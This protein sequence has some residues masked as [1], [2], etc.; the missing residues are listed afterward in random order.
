MALSPDTFD[1]QSWQTAAILQYTWSTSDTRTN[2]EPSPGRRNS[3]RVPAHPT[4]LFVKII[5]RTLAPLT[6]FRPTAT[7]STAL[8]MGT[9][10]RRKRRECID[11]HETAEVTGGTG[12]FAHAT[13]H[14]DL[15]GQLDFTTSPPSFFLP[16]QGTIQVVGT[17]EG[18]TR[19][20]CT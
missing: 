9:L 1:S 20:L 17:D 13:G 5:F 4:R 10:A 15:A 18:G 11:N 19:A 7:K 2:W 14:F 6:G 8:S 12:R 16:W 3:S